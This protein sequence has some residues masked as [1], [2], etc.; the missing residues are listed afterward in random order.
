MKR[1]SRFGFGAL[2][3]VVVSIMAVVLYQF[4]ISD[5]WVHRD[6]AAPQST[7]KPL[8]SMTQTVSGEWVSKM[9]A[10]QSVDMRLHDFRTPIAAFPPNIASNVAPWAN[11]FNNMVPSKSVS[12]EVFSSY[13]T[14]EF[15]A[16]M[17]PTA[18]AYERLVDKLTI[19]RPSLAINYWIE[20]RKDQV[21]LAYVVTEGIDVPGY[22]PVKSYKIFKELQ[23]R[24]L[25]HTDDDLAL[26]E[27]RKTDRQDV[28][29]Y[30]E[31]KTPE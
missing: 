5:N 25:A 22:P 19:S 7:D 18:E 23:G 13:V 20:A 21:H 14:E 12:Y 2:V 28:Q 31:K 15:R 29:Q 4:P 30:L 10:G 24:W 16:M 9:V 6:A 11:A 8:S 3:L 1:M 27:F 17:A 26:R